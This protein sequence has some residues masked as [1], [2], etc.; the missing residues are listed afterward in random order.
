MPSVDDYYY[1]NG[2]LVRHTW[3]QL[4]APYW[5]AESASW[6][7]ETGH[8]VESF[9]PAFG[10]LEMTRRSS[11]RSRKINGKYR[12]SNP[13]SFY[14][15]KKVE[16]HG[17]KSEGYI[18]SQ[19]WETREEY[20][21][22]GSG[23]GA[24]LNDPFGYWDIQIASLED[25]TTKGWNKLLEKIS[26]Q[27][28]NLGNAAGERKQTFDFIASLAKTAAKGISGI[29]NGKLAADLIEGMYDRASYGAGWVPPSS[30]PR[31]DRRKRRRDAEKKRDD[32]I[33]RARKDVR[34]AAQATLAFEYGLKPLLDDIHGAAENFRR[35][36]MDGSTEVFTVRSSDSDQATCV[37]QVRDQEGGLS[38]DGSGVLSISVKSAIRYRIS[39][40]ALRDLQQLGLVNPL[41]IAWEVTPWSF[42][43]DWFANIGSFINAATATAGCS[44]VDGYTTTCERFSGTCTMSRSKSVGGRFDNASISTS[45][46]W[47]EI[48][49]TVHSGFPPFTLRR[50]GG[51]DSPTRAMEA[52]S[53]A[54]TNCR[55]P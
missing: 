34:K 6:V 26:S 39:N 14:N 45:D 36:F 37:K 31:K 21:Q 24:P 54:I 50:K 47:V 30:L 49:R 29:K 11:V 7:P 3:K 8:I 41:S 48:V 35:R 19:P 46:R 20:T 43:A 33:R 42:V 22:S 40:P 38:I 2:G 23:F 5:N 16:W 1:I 18:P 15:R 53:L 55:K 28:I 10:G 17:W 44:F 27:D 13:Y 12:S 51:I 4:T 9:F 25:L 32:D 52:L